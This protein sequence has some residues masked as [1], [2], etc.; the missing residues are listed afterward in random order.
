MTES[1]AAR[2]RSNAEKRLLRE[3]VR[4]LKGLM[5]MQDVT[6]NMVWVVPLSTAQLVEDGPSWTDIIIKHGRYFHPF[7]G[8]WPKTPPNYIGF[9]FWGAVQE[10]RHV[11][12]S[13]LSDA[14]WRRF[15]V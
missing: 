6:S 8:K 13:V 3:F 10:I 7:A 14:P 11:E 12:E 15:L 5:T 2:S 1:T 9:R 4:Y